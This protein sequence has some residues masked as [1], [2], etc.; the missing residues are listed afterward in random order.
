VSSII[1]IYGVEIN[2]PQPEEQEYIEDWGTNEPKEQYWR[3]KSLPAFFEQV[4][5]DT[6]GN[7][8]LSQRQREY[9]NAE[10]RRCKKGFFFKSNGETIYITGKNYFYL[11][12]WK[13]EDDIYADFRMSDRK[14]FLYLDHWE[15]V[16]WCLGI[17]RGKPRRAG[18]TSQATANLIYECIF[19][20]NSLCGLTSKT[21][22]DAKAAFTNMV[23][24]GYR[25]LP[26]FLKPKQ[27]N[28]KDSVTELV[29][30]HKSTET[31]GARGNVI[32]NDTGHRS[33][34]DY[35]A[36][37][38]NA[39][40]SGRISR[41]LADEMGK[42]ASDVPASQ[43]LS[44]VSK[45]LVKGGKRVG[46]CE[47]PSTVN[48]LTKGG[49]EQF[50]LMWDVAD[51][52]KNKERTPNRIVRYF[53]PAY[54][55]YVGFIDK[56]GNSVID[57]PTQEQYDW[58]VENFVGAGDLT[59]EDIALG[60]KKYLLHKRASLEGVALE[61]EIRMTPF[62]E[63][64]MFMLRNSNCHFDAVLLNSLYEQA[65]ATE[66]SLI[67][68][69]NWTWKDGMPFTEA[70]W[71][72]CS[73]EFA[74]WHRPKGFKIPEGP[75]VQKRGSLFFPLNNIQII[76]GCDPFQNNIVETGEGSKASS[77][78]LNRYDT[79]MEDDFYNMLIISKYHARPP[80]AKLLHMDMILQCFAYGCQILIEAKMDGGMR[81]FFIDNN[82]EGFLI[83][84]GDKA[85][86]GIDPNSDNKV[87][88]VNLWEQYILTHGKQGKLIY[89]DIIDDKKDGLIK[90]DVN[91]TE[92][93]NQ[94]M[95]CGYALVA[96]YFKKANFKKLDTMPITSYFKRH[97]VA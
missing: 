82:C 72:S 2:L 31:K 93:S 96:N 91:Y 38:L 87:L 75:T 26:V 40:D 15:K 83:R 54:D 49:G 55:G 44:I 78:I 5:Y 47:L 11:Q 74:R 13:L 84:I 56:F 10:V 28:N 88:M 39:Y 89:P 51:F 64:E 48:E 3:R 62:D 22:G 33:K 69:G 14:Y 76:A 17:I 20:R 8:V 57:K 73:K 81:D 4:E 94:V 7:A 23:S 66:S 34:I 77:G 80:M 92:H 59:E 52:E 70:V 60:A 67:E 30:A 24:F 6:D 18:A 65:K 36:P 79:M 1:T 37:S 45:T 27:L 71:E 41:L 43:F 95:G 12:W 86:Y 21:Q 50:K 68:Y 42:W 63:R 97:K 25:Q 9:A 35:K 16:T 53:C 32:D 85:N 61:E 90:F 46:F 29:F 19:F 58:L